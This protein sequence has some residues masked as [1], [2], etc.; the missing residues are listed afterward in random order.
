MSRMRKFLTD[1]GWRRIGAQ[2]S[3]G[4]WDHPEHQPD[5][6]GAFTTTDAFKHQQ[7][8]EKDHC[9]DCIKPEATR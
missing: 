2:G 8:F 1:R 9:C 6:R 4:Y 3:I 7:Q 5:R